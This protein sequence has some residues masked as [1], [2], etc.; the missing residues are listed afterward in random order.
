M[1][2][3]PMTTV[4]TR[5]SSLHR[6]LKLDMHIEWSNAGFYYIYYTHARTHI[7]HPHPQQTHT[8]TRTHAHAR[9]HPRTHPPT[10]APPPPPTHTEEEEIQVS[11]DRSE[12]VYCCEKR[13]GFFAFFLRSSI[14]GVAYVTVLN[15]PATWTATFRLRA[16]K[17][18]LVI[19]VL[20]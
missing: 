11:L 10:P 2:P 16:Y 14:G 19:F 9:T 5:R 20:P 3:S 1:T 17:C 15:S 12:V 7:R 4:C 13:C 18:M 6:P 8:H